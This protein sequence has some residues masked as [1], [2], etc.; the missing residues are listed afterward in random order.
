MKKLKFLSHP[1]FLFFA[2]LTIA[3]PHSFA[4]ESPGT[5]T[6]NTAEDAKAGTKK[7]VRK[8]KRQVRKAT[9]NDTAAKDVRDKVN[10]VS[11]DTEKNVNKA[12]NNAQ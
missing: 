12:K 2:L 3:Q 9:G 6:K 5:A 7:T 10:D 11:D 4:D 1:T 8:A